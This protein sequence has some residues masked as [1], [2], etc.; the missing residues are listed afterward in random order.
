MA[1]VLRRARADEIEA[2]IAVIVAEGMPAMELERWIEQFWVLDDG[3]TLLGCA[4][5]EN[6]GEAA[7]LRS[8]A[9]AQPLRGTG[10]GVRLVERSLEYAK[11]LGAKRCYLFTMTAEDFFPRFGFERCSLEDFEPSVR[12][13]WQYRGNVEHEELR[14]MLIPMRATLSR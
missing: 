5:V 9:V 4:G 8:V 14:K 3:G 12:E 11:G 1:V 7:V 10:W 13:C 2:V 6:Y